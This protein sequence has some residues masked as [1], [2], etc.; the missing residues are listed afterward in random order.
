MIFT[1]RPME[2]FWAGRMI[3]GLFGPGFLIIPS[4]QVS[5]GLGRRLA[6]GYAV[7]L[8]L[9]QL[10]NEGLTFPKYGIMSVYITDEMQFEI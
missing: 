3:S 5:H 6:W 4:K 10:S 9:T 7:P 8:S 2:L 1:P